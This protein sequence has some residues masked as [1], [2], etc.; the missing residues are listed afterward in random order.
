M[1]RF[2]MACPKPLLQSLEAS[3]KSPRPKISLVKILFLIS[4]L[5]KTPRT[6]SLSE[7]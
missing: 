4:E 5:H 7:G 3:I 2:L 1:Q 6:Y